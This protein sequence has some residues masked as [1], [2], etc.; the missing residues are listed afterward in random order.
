M[1][2]K[3]ITNILKSKKAC[4]FYSSKYQSPCSFSDIDYYIFL[5]VHSMQN[6]LFNLECLFHSQLK[7]KVVLK[8]HTQF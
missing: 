7:I 1:K 3:D 2:R 4:V 8:R 5:G 6:L